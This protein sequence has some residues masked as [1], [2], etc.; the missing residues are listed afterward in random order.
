LPSPVN[1]ARGSERGK[2]Q[3]RKRGMVERLAF[4]RSY[5]PLQRGAARQICTK[6]AVH[7]AT[8]SRTLEKNSA[9]RYRLLVATRR[10]GFGV[11]LDYQGIL[12]VLIFRQYAS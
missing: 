11:P 5:F 10:N 6:D 3:E 7:R 8:N 1:R 9:P 12:K 4:S 2:N